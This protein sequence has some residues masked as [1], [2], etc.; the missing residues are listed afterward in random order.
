LTKYFKLLTILTNGPLIPE[1]KAQFPN[2]PYI[3]RPAISTR[4]IM[5]ILSR[6]SRE[7][8]TD[9]YDAEGT[10]ARTELNEPLKGDREILF[11]RVYE[12][13]DCERLIMLII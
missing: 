6:R 11:K 4:K 10:E 5:K 3:A 2:T 12:V 13:L 8:A 9:S 7:A 1:L